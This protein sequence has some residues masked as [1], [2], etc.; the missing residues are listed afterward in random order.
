MPTIH[1][2]GATH[3]T[4]TRTKA[5]RAK[6]GVCCAAQEQAPF[7]V[8]PAADLYNITAQTGNHMCELDVEPQRDGECRGS[9][10]DLELDSGDNV[11]SESSEEAYRTRVTRSMSNSVPRRNL[12]LS[13]GRGRGRGRGHGRQPLAAE[14]PSLCD[15]RLVHPDK[16]KVPDPLSCRLVGGSGSDDQWIPEH[17]KGPWEASKTVMLLRLP[18]QSRFEKWGLWR[19]GEWFEAGTGTD[20]RSG[21]AISQIEFHTHPACLGYSGW[22]N[23]PSREDLVNIVARSAFLQEQCAELIVTPAGAFFMIVNSE[24][25]DRLR[26][27]E[28]EAVEWFK[29]ECLPPVMDLLDTLKHVIGYRQAVLDPKQEKGRG[30]S[31]YAPYASLTMDPLLDSL[32]TAG[33]DVVWWSAPELFV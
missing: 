30:N 33:I 18:Y 32:A 2:L 21:S 27:W 10:V 6:G 23:I 31:I 3:Q 15:D 28:Q 13:H 7:R 17:L 29:H 8:G 19:D 5:R 1:D 4:A 25:L 24:F 26:E 11:L 14:P 20:C 16:P 9:G 12:S 22:P